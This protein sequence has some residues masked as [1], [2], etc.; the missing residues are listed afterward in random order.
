MQGFITVGYFLIGLL[1]S[2]V[3]FAL[4]SRLIL[5]L[6]KVSAI[7]PVNQLV[8]K[9]TDPVVKPIEKILASKNYLQRAYDLPCLVAIVLT[10]LLKFI[11]LG[12]FLYGRLLPIGYLVLFTLTDL[13]VQPCNLFFYLILIRV[14]MSYVQP[15]WQGPMAEVIKRLTDPLLSLGRKIIP[16]ISGFDFSPFIIMI[17]LKVIVLFVGAS[18]PLR[19]A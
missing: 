13:I 15:H 10:S 17:I 3:L 18:L 14:I 1:F 7:H 8:D 4:W 11:I 19:L 5:R 12:L 16:D 2:L 6:L 9:L